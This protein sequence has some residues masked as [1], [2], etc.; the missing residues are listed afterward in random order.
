MMTIRPP[1]L[2][3]VV[4]FVKVNIGAFSC[5]SNTKLGLH[6]RL[7]I[8]AS[9]VCNERP[10]V[11]FSRGVE[12]TPLVNTSKRQ[13]CRPRYDQRLTGGLRHVGNWRT[14]WV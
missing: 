5:V 11:M 14:L 10:K 7:L 8:T 3:H 9:G 12:G 2:S 6:I 13:I 4:A 1:G